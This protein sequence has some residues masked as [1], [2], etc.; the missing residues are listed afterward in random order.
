[1]LAIP[2]FVFVI[3]FLIIYSYVIII[4]IIFQDTVPET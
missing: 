2:P 4:P 1:M 3:Q